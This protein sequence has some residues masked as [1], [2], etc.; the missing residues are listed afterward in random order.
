VYLTV[1]PY[2]E[3]FLDAKFGA[4]FAD[5]KTRGRALI[6]GLRAYRD[7]VRVAPDF[8]AGIRGESHVPVFLA[9]FAVAAYLL[10]V[11]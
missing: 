10:F 5:Y 3:R 9:A 1:I 11:R 8:M 4:A 6:P 7:G 2:E